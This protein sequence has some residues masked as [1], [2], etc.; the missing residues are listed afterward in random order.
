MCYLP[1]WP[2]NLP[3][4]Q[5]CPIP[6]ETHVNDDILY[7]SLIDRVSFKQNF[8]TQLVDPEDDWRKPKPKCVRRV[9]PYNL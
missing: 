3:G 4:K 9:E 8:S 6:N 2:V 1:S 5:W 7:A